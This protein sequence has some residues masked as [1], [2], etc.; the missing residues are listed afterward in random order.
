L[1][2]TDVGLT[3]RTVTPD[4]GVLV[5]LDEGQ[6]VEQVANLL[7]DPQGAQKLGA[8]GRA[9][10]LREFNTE[11]YLEYLQ[12]LHDFSTPGPIV[13]GK[14]VRPTEISTAASI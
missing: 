12:Q 3:R 6:I 2:A 8:A 1:V 9:K 4:V 13:R 7:A 11:D 10:V 5:S 14:R